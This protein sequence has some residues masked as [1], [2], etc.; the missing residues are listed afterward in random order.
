MK[1]IKI[2]VIVPVYNVENY[3]EKCLDSIIGQTLK[4]I[5][6]I[7]VNDGSTDKSLEILEE[8]KSRD[9]RI[10]V[11]SQENAGLSVARNIAIDVAKGEFLSFVDSDDYIDERMLEIMLDKA[12]KESSDI[13]MCNFAK[14]N[15]SGE[16]MEC[17][18]IYGNVGKEALFLRLLSA[19]YYSV[20]WSNIYKKR[21]FV[22][23]NIYYPIGLYHEDVPTTYRLFYYANKVSV[24]E[25]VLYKWLQREGSIGKS[26]T[27]KHIDDT[28]TVFKMTRDFLIEEDLL[29]KYNMYYIRRIYNFVDTL[30]F[31]INH[32]SKNEIDK[33]NKIFQ[34]IQRLKEEGYETDSSLKILREY[35]F[36]LYRRYI[37][38]L[39]SGCRQELQ[40]CKRELSTKKANLKKIQQSKG[41]KLL[42][43]LYEFKNILTL[44]G[45]NSSF[46]L[47]LQKSSEITNNEII[48]LESLKNKYS[49]KRCFIIG[50]GP[51]LNKL[52]LTYLKDEFTFGVN[53]IFYKTEEMG[54]KPTFYMVEDNHVIDDNIDNINAYDVDYKFFPSIYKDK[55]K[56]TDNTYFFNADLGFYD[57]SFPYFCIPRFSK[58]FS[59]ISYAGQSVTYMNMQLAYYLGFK[60]VYLIGMDF[61]YAI[62]K[63]DK[64]EGATL[65]SNEDD[66][67]H[68][69][70]DYFGKGKKWHDPKVERVGWN[71][72]N[73]KNTFE[74]EGR[75]IY[76][77]TAGGKLEIFD[78]VEYNI[79]FK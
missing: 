55:I 14:V 79:L 71:Y 39:K 28:F 33:H 57:A 58:N 69:H 3:L 75:K 49:G 17:S 4:E 43:K 68:F 12:Y 34:V 48:K 65:I 24:V 63:S 32:Y 35:D 60:E 42:L 37:N 61:S 36:N 7:T 2:S 50:N 15:D 25:D 9:S 22:D 18:S 31:K 64:V 10:I 52:D 72:E 62:R 56:K 41:F 76:N 59:K 53:G 30:I 6:I 73:A 5:E 20:S 54:I 19:N 23:N 78:R 77:A 1:K 45:S 21:L 8:Y 51:S 66:I 67:N 70:P 40:K 13:V 74:K 38:V 11:I 29:K 27:Q 16:S 26:L 47:P 44:K 46:Q